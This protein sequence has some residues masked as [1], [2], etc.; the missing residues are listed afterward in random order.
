MK[1][2]I[3][4]VLGQHHQA[5]VYA[6]SEPELHELIRRHKPWLVLLDAEAWRSAAHFMMAR[7]V[8]EYKTVKFAVF[9]WNEILF[10]HALRFVQFG[11]ASILGFRYDD[12]VYEGL[13]AV[14]RGFDYL[15]TEISAALDS[16]EMKDI[17]HLELTKTERS[18]YELLIMGNEDEDIARRLAMALNT[19]RTHKRSIYSKYG[20]TNYRELM[21]FALDRRDLP[22]HGCG[23]CKGMRHGTSVQKRFTHTDLNCVS[24]KNQCRNKQNIF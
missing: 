18:V 5:I 10:K 17:N 3:Q 23:E 20:V 11:A 6:H 8:K 12:G 16:V 14:M 7:L 13:D 24:V 21:H 9:I 2:T 1:Q 19:V 4:R 15:P 22:G